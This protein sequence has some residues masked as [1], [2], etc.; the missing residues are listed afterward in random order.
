VLTALKAPLVIPMHFFSTYTLNRFT[1]RLSKDWDI[2]MAEVP[3]WSFATDIAGR[4]RSSWCCQVV[5]SNAPV[6]MA[7]IR[8][9]V[10]PANGSDMHVAECGDGPLVLLCHGWPDCG[11]PWRHQMRALAAAGL[12]PARPRPNMRGFG[13]TTAPPDVAAYRFST[14]S[15]TWSRWW[16][17]S[18]RNNALI[19]GHD[20]G[21][22]SPGTRR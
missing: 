15:A 17:R 10:I 8:H 5:P 12:S 16:T 9:R 21:R 7:D 11:I 1:E 20:W 18:A 19:V 4:A 14:M 3:R 2:E 6:L 13:R 22:R